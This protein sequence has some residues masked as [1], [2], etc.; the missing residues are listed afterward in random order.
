M[1][2]SSKEILHFGNL[3]EG[4][5]IERPNRFLVIGDVK[6]EQIE[7]HLKDPGRLVDLMICGAQMLFKRVEGTTKRRT[8]FDVVAVM[9][10]DSA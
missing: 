2:D 8:Q 7:A 9:Q 4:T 10:H 5:F 3:I 6:G 1:P